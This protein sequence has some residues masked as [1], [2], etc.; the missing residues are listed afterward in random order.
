MIV[1]MLAV[2]AVILVLIGVAVERIA[3]ALE[4]RNLEPK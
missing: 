4:K 1:F 2:I 3:E